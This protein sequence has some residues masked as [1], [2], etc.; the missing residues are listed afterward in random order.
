V[1]ATPGRILLADPDAWSLE[2]VWDLLRG[3]GYEVVG[4]TCAE[5]AV[6]AILRSEHEFDVLLCDLGLEVPVAGIREQVAAVAPGLAERIVWLAADADSPRAFH[7]LL[8]KPLEKEGACAC[9]DGYVVHRTI[10]PTS[11]R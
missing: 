8:R 2:A 3:A 6:L 5:D 11:E 10:A 9:I 4:C 1:T 7:P